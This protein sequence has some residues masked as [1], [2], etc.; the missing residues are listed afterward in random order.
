[1]LNSTSERQRLLDALSA[2]GFPAD[3]QI[4]AG[5]AGVASPIRVATEWAGYRVSSA[6]G[7]W[8]AKVLHADMAPLID[9]ARSA[10]AS[11]C[12]AATGAAPALK[13]ADVANGVLL[14]EALPAPQWRWA[15]LDE[16]TSPLRLQALWALKKQVH[17]GPTPDFARSPMADLQKLRALCLRDGVSLPPDHAWIDTCIDL[18]WEALQQHPGQSVPLHGDGLASDV[19]VGPAGELRLIDFDYGGCFDPWYDVAITL[20]ELYPFE[21]QWREGIIAWAGQCRESDYARCRF[22]A[23]INDWYWTLW[24]L[25]VGA[26]S[27]RNLEFSKV[28]QWTLLR[29]RQTIQDAR[30]ESWLRQVQEGQA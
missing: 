19:M 30:F 12:A 1:M 11:A 4:S 21:S 5:T 6:L 25:W 13:S 7:T 20:N 16:L 2:A 9:V 26:T 15:R 27:T 22:Y 17:A 18:A 28:G 23:L 8:Y 10:Q 3:S 14:F 24:G 29:C